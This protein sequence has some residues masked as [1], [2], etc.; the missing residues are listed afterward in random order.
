MLIHLVRRGEEGRKNVGVFNT[1]S[2]D[3]VLDRNIREELEIGDREEMVIVYVTANLTNAHRLLSEVLDEASS[4]FQVDIEWKHQF[5]NTS[6]STARQQKH[7]QVISI[8]RSNTQ[9]KEQWKAN[10]DITLVK[11]F[12]FPGWPPPPAGWPHPPDP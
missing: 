1:G 4:S 10:N 11:Y 7:L 6:L 2:N 9:C 3:L 5:G 8:F 12:T